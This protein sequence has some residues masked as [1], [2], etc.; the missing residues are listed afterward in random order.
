MVTSSLMGVA[1]Q[2]PIVMTLLI[3]FKVIKHKT[4]EK[5]RPF[6]YVI[7]LAFAAILPPT[8]L[9]SL[10]LLTLPLVILFE[11]TLILNRMF[12]KTHLI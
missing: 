11:T 8:D 2:Y 1:F 12:L 7:A 9:F 10:I 4:F 6:A 3:R 5:Q